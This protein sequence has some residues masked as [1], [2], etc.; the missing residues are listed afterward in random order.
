MAKGQKVVTLNL[1][2][3]EADVLAA[4][5]GTQARKYT[6][7]LKK[8]PKAKNRALLQSRQTVAHV[9]EDIQTVDSRACQ[10]WHAR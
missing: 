7:V 4:M 8:Y 2:Q 9:I 3:E 1:F 5:L 10:A 6:A